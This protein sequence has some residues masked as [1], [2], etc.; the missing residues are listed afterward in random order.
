MLR[1]AVVDLLGNP[2]QTSTLT[3][4]PVSALRDE[5]VRC[6]YGTNAKL[7]LEALYFSRARADRGDYDLV[8]VWV[9]PD[10]EVVQYERWVTD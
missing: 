1:S 2:L 10:D 7:P 8:C 3:N 5:S 4:Y 6:H 9:G